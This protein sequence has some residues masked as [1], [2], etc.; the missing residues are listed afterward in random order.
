MSWAQQIEER[1]VG[2]IKT[3]VAASEASIVVDGARV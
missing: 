3:V 1:A 2:A